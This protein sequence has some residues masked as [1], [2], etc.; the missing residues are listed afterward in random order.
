MKNRF[1]ER[2]QHALAAALGCA[3]AMGHTYIGSEHILLGLLSDADSIAGK[4]L[5]ARN[6]DADEVRLAVI[7]LSGRGT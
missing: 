6:T 5:A 1:T 2:A 4:M 7:E 3:S